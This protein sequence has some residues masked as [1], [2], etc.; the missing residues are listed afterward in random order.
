M[1]RID[2]RSRSE[3]RPMTESQPHPFLRNFMFDASISF[4]SK[5][6]D[7]TF[8]PRIPTNPLRFTAWLISGFSW[9]RSEL[10]LRLPPLNQNRGGLIRQIYAEVVQSGLLTTLEYLLIAYFVVPAIKFASS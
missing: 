2:L 10:I 9:K 4:C 1:R 8:S 5:D 6:Q 7:S 3:L